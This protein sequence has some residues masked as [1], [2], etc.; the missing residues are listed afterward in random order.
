MPLRNL[1]S[2]GFANLLGR[3]IVI[4]YVAW[5]YHNKV[6]IMDNFIGT[7]KCLQEFSLSSYTCIKKF[8]IRELLVSFS[9]LKHLHYLNICDTEIKDLPN[10]VRRLY[11]LQS[12]TLSCYI[13]DL[14]KNMG[15]LVNL[16]H[17]DNSRTNIKEMPPQI[18]KLK[19]L[20]KFPHFVVGKNGGSSIRELRVVQHLFGKL[21]IELG[22]CSL[23]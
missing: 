5:I 7:F 8:R 9:N 13:T 22:K 4:I 2:L 3:R 19:N 20:K 6:K 17:F 11:N 12:L 10:S 16:H 18:G 14:P 21:S 23:C 1:R 15:K